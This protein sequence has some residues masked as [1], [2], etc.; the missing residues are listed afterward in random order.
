MTATS[1][2]VLCGGRSSRMGRAKAW[3]PWAGRPML[4]HVVERLREAVDDVVVVSAPDQSL[5]RVE[6]RV[7][8]DREE[9][10]GP[11]AGLREGIGAA[12]GELVF[13]TATDAPHLSVAF[14]H[15]LLAVGGA[16]AP[17]L[18][19]RVQ[20]LSAAYPAEAAALADRLIAEGR[21]RPL[22]L[23]EA[24]DYVALDA[25][26]L[27]DVDSVRG[28]N[29]PDEYLAAVDDEPSGGVVLEL[30]GR[31]RVRAGAASLEVGPGRLGDVLGSVADRVG[32]IDGDRVARAYAVSL[33]GRTFLRD[34]AVP[35]GPGEH[36]I[37]FDAAVGG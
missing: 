15:A 11:L 37:V 28:F 12:R 3:L 29:T 27:P 21:R 23:L 24:L 31:A 17:V 32:L 30:L 25:E 22:D 18:G 13:V 14:V 16:A 9:G 36:V 34:L 2:I 19:G 10:L 5:P 20:P 8:A 7:V 33:E 4:V 35:I 26:A 1:G 6:A